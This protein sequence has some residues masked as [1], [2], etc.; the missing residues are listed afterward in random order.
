V[1]GEDVV[2]SYVDGTLFLAYEATD[3]VTEITLPTR[4]GVWPGDAA[5]VR[6]SGFCIERREDRLLLRA[7]TPGPVSLE[8]GR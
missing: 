3:G 6:G 2:A 8:L 1:A 5:N 4:A 7:D